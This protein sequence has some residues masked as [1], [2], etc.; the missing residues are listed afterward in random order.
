MAQKGQPTTF[1]ERIEIGE[2]W[3]TGQSDPE[4]AAAM[5]RSVWTVRKWRRKY[6]QEGRSGLVSRMGRP[7]TGALGQYSPE[8]R[9]AISE[10]REAHPGWGPVTIQ[11]ELDNDP[12]YST[13]KL[14]SRARL[15]VYLHQEGFT[16]KYE[17]HSELPQPKAVEPGQ[18]HEI[19]EVDAQG[20]IKIPGLGSVSIINVKDLFSRVYVDSYPCLNTTHPSRLDYQLILRRAFVNWG[21]PEQI[22][23]DHDSVFYDNASASPYP[24][25]LHLW[26]IALGIEVRFIEQKPPVEHSVIERSH[27]TVDQQAIAGQSFPDSMDLLKSLSDRLDFLNLCYPSLALGGQPP[28][29]ACPEAKQSQRPYRLEWEEEMLDMQRVYDYLAEGRWFRQTSTQGQFSLGTYYYNA[30]THLSQQTLEIT[31]DPQTRELVC[32]SEDGNQTIRFF[33][34]GLSKADLMGELRPLVTLPAYQL[35]LPFSRATW[36][37]IMLCGDLTGTTL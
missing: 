31:F 33:C 27:Q 17:R 32:L 14:P 29:V 7:P 26:L 6:Q 30:K 20:V 37:E 15:A 2:R 35:E 18:A 13:E 9:Q 10:M 11:T 36:R 8:I 34:Q 4:I 19:W 21:L 23:L 1:E 28:L 24:T 3:E 5:M 16:R 12:E 25:I 22:S